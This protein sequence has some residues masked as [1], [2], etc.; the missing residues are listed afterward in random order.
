[1]ANVQLQDGPDVFRWNLY[2]NGKL[3]VDSMYSALIQPGI[4][5]AKTDNDKLW[6]LK[7]ALRVYLDGTFG[8][9]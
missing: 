2:E 1:L 6:K 7:L 3:S 4:P 5:I 8:R 9:E